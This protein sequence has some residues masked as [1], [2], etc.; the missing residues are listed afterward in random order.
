MKLNTLVLSVMSVV[1][2]ATNNNVNDQDQHNKI[3]E[4]T[5]ELGLI[6]D[7]YSNFSVSKI[8][9]DIKKKLSKEKIEQIKNKLKETGSINDINLDNINID[10]IKNQVKDEISKIQTQINSENI[11]IKEYT[12]EVKSYYKRIAT[13]AKNNYF[14]NDDGQISSKNILSKIESLTNE[15]NEFKATFEEVSNKIQ[16]LIKLSTTFKTLTAVLASAAAVSYICSF[17]SFGSSAVFATVF[18]VGAAI[19]GSIASIIDMIIN[20]HSKTLNI[21]SDGIITFSK[22]KETN[23]WE[24]SRK[25]L[26]MSLNLS[27]APLKLAY[28]TL[29]V[30]MGKFG[31]KAGT[32]LSIASAAINVADAIKSFRELS[33]HN[34]RIDDFKNQFEETGMHIGQMKKVKWT[35]I[36]ETVQDNPYYMGG[37]GGVNTVFKNL[38]TNEVKTLEDMLK[39]SKFEL[40]SMGLT[41]SKHPKT[42]EYI[43]TLPNKVKFDN[44]G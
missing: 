31:A 26:T 21:L 14:V 7:D 42:G 28:S 30:N 6:E 27:K 36:N 43:K 20:N 32:Y 2:T 11:N 19:T 18:S 29:L 24:L 13:D 41:K 12:K 44:L 8:N 40:Y 1:Q 37:T 39:Y 3:I 17:F 9:R 34:D 10:E 4:L 23:P 25:A 5:N 38:E 33:E 35:V 22:S 16:L 15:L